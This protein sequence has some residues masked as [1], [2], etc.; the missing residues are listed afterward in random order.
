MVPWT[1]HRLVPYG[2]QEVLDCCRTTYRRLAHP[3]CTVCLLHLSAIHLPRCSRSSLMCKPYSPPC[4]QPLRLPDGVAPSA[5]I[6]GSMACNGGRRSLVTINL[7]LCTAS[8]AC[9]QER[10]MVRVTCQVKDFGSSSPSPTSANQDPSKE[11][12]VRGPRGQ[13]CA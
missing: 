1:D 8:K 6:S 2:S 5:T 13:A 9:Q 4:S 11:G 12:N 10:A 7:S 3:R